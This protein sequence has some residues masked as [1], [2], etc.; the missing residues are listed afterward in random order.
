M[1]FIALN[2]CFRLIKVFI[3]FLKKANNIEWMH[4]LYKGYRA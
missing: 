3:Y 4:I 1:I 2:I